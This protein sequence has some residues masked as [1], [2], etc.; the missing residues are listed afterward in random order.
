MSSKVHH[1]GV[2]GGG[3]VW[4]QGGMHAGSGDGF[5]RYDEAVDGRGYAE[6]ET[7]NYE[8]YFGV[9]EIGVWGFRS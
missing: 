8:E 1:V 7:Q 6:T 5:A 3:K 9:V 2:T 4:V